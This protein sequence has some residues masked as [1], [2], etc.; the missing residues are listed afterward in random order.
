M[1]L[2]YYTH[3]GLFHCDEVTGFA[4]CKL[5]GIC[6][7]FV[8]L[9]DISNIPTDGLV[10]DIGRVDDPENYRFDH[11]QDFLL[12]DNGYPY[13]S[14]GL[15]WAEFGRTIIRKYTNQ[16]IDVIWERVDKKLIQ[17][18]DAHD[19]DAKYFINT[20][21]SAGEVEI[22]SLPNV[23]SQFN[24]KDVSNA[25]AQDFCFGLAVDLITN[26]LESVINQAIKYFEDI[27]K[28]DSVFILDGEVGYLREGL[29]WKEIVAERYPNLKFMI[30]PSNHPGNPY[31]MIAVPITPISREVKVPI[32][33]PEWFKGFIHNGKWIAGSD[34]IAE[35]L[36]LAKYNLNS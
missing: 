11:H 4:I 19:S 35:L 24:S 2:T 34:S 36:D 6:D 32:E 7:S 25:E 20:I 21:C 27:V 22:L 15:L 12:R 31:S 10:A 8:R 17:G 13:A 18:I 30:H 33:R 1:K 14:A 26:V 29:S 3:G 5:A 9:T 28:F 16:N 23:I